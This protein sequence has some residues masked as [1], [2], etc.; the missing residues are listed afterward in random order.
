MA[1]FET[2]QAEANRL[3]GTEPPALPEIRK[4]MIE[5]DEYFN[6]PEFQDLDK[7]KRGTLQAL[8]KELRVRVRGPETVAAAS[9]ATGG[10]FNGQ[11]FPLPENSAALA[12]PTKPREH[13]PQAESFMS[14]A[15]KLF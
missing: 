10:M 4:M 12:S 15:E 8:F 14:E 11:G 2:I 1:D 7:E 3:L 6:S 5:M 13:N 9:P